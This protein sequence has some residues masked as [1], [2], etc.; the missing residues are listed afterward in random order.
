MTFLPTGGRDRDVTPHGT[1]GDLRTQPA[2]RPQ[3]NIAG[4][5]AAGNSAKS[6]I[7][8]SIGMRARSVRDDAQSNDERVQSSSTTIFPRFSPRSR[9]P[10][11][12][13]AAASP[14]TVS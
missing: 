14:L 9:R 2:V 7:T 6:S 12:D 4:I 5:I 10:S 11:A 13:G 1:D 8:A 3:V